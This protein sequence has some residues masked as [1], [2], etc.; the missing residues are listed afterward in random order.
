L[1]P[2][3]PSPARPREC[4][5]RTVTR[6][7]NRTTKPWRRQRGTLASPHP[8]QESVGGLPEKVSLVVS[9]TI[10][11]GAPTGSSPS[12]SRRWAHTI[13]VDKSWLAK[14]LSLSNRIA[15]MEAGTLL[16]VG[17][18]EAIYSRPRARF[19]STFVGEANVLPG[20]RRNGRVTLVDGATFA[21]PG[22]DGDVT[23]VVRPQDLI[24]SDNDATPEIAVAGSLM[25]IVF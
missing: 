15:V 20:R 22:A 4:F 6:P 13:V 12:T 1:R 5:G 14:A 17:A 10:R 7:E 18:P 23:V 21:S 24:I 8:W 2:S 11:S 19:V 25:D 16:Q 3:M 9:G